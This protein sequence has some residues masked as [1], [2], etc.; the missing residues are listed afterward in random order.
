M[1]E[2]LRPDEAARALREIQ[3][4]QTPVVDLMT[5]PAWYW[6]SVAALVVVLS[7]GVDMRTPLAIGVSVTVFVVGML[8][9]TLWFTL[10]AYRR[11]IPRNGL[12]DGRA[13]LAIVSLV[14]LTVGVTLGLAFGLRAAGVPYPA[15]VASVPGGL[16]LGLGGTALSGYLRRIMLGNRDGVRP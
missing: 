1:D 13:A 3:D 5:V 6:W 8:A 2:Q 9:S 7:V 14:A 4:R 11:A 16:I 12:L 10:G 15:T